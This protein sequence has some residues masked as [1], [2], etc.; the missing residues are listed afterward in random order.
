MGRMETL[1][2]DYN[3][4]HQPD[5]LVLIKRFHI[6]PKLR[7]RICMEKCVLCRRGYY[8]L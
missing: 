1:F 5:N 7:A 8:R 6:S 3:C 4:V 2:E